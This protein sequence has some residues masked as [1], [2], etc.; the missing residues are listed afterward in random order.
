MNEV[1]KREILSLSKDLGEVGLDS[2]LENGLFKDAPIIGTG[3]SIAKL[4][5]SVSDRILLTKIIHFI[6]EL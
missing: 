4:I 6:N 5:N 2:L 3:I 1:E